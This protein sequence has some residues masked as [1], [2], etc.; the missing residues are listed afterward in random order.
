MLF[1]A[2]AR[3]ALRRGVDAVADA[4]RV[5]LGPSGRRVV[6]GGADGPVVTAD[7]ATVAAAVELADPYANL[8]AAL[9]REAAERTRAAV[10]DGTTTTIVLTQALVAAGM[11]AVA[12]GAHPAALRRGM[13]AAVAAVVAHLDGAARPM[14]GEQEMALVAAAAAGDREWGEVIARACAKTGPQGA[15][16]VETAHVPGV[17]AE[18]TDGFVLDRGFLSP[19]MMTHPEQG[20]AVLENAYVLLH[21]GT[22]ESLD[23]LLPVL[24]R[25]AATGRPLLVVA[26]GLRQDVLAALVMNRLRGTLLCAAVEAPA[27][28]DRRRT[29]LEDLAALTGGQVVTPEKGLPL[30]RVTPA[31]LGDVARVVVTRTTTTVTGGAGAPEA[32]RG[33]VAHLERSLRTATDAFDREVLEQRLARLTG[34]LCVLKVGADSDTEGA[35]RR[36]RITG[37]VAAARA[38]AAEGTVPGGGTALLRAAAALE[39]GL[40]LAGDERTGVLTVRAALAAPLRRIA[41]AAGMDGAHL[42]ARAAMAPAGHG[43][44]AATD[45]WCDLAAAGVLDPVRVPRTALHNAASVAGLLLTAGGL[46]V[47][48]RPAD[49]DAVSWRRRGHGHHHA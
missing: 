16:T 21:P 22:I 37:A 1:E 12:A 30:E 20:E 42:A 43:W 2:D 10:G 39:D 26:G 18:F 19:L 36:Q 33:R 7:G 3:A 9:V 31:E 41:A 6:I 25:V 40:A 14:S 34:G 45:R 4:A 32:V 24:D 38:A 46:V 17:E 23:A 15:V 13:D 8:G 47:N 28:G 48:H 49:P 44:D 27:L 35:E 29:H 11:R 5:T